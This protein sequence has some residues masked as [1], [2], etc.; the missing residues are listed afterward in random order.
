VILQESIQEYFLCT[1]QDDHLH[2][3]DFNLRLKEMRRND[4]YSSPAQGIGQKALYSEHLELIAVG[5]SSLLGTIPSPELDQTAPFQ[6][7]HLLSKDMCCD[8]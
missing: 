3:P 6:V 7:K 4:E 2:I 8:A 1:H 5:A